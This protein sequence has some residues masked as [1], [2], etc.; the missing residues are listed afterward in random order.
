M[1]A[2]PT[3]G[4]DRFASWR[5][6]LAKWTVGPERL[7][8]PREQAAFRVFTP[9]SSAGEPLN[10][11]SMLQPDRGDLADPERRADRVSGAAAALLGLVGIEADPIQSPEH[12]LL[13]NILEFFWSQGHEVTLESLLGA[14]QSPPVTKLGI[15]PVDEL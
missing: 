11:L 14:I 8:Q 15:F 10:V 13:A 1:R 4:G 2:G 6:G 12:I 9:G 3:G 7:A 5:D